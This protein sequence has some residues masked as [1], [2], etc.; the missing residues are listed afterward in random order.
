M[1]VRFVVKATMSDVAVCGN[2]MICWIE[3]TSAARNRC[4]LARTSN[5]I[6]FIVFFLCPIKLL[7]SMTCFPFCTW[8][9]TLQM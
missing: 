7:D 4:V 5:V 2:G 6:P 3:K 9:Q 8:G 1:S